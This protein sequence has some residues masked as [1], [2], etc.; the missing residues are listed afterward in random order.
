[1]FEI[2]WLI[3]LKF[4]DQRKLMRTTGNAVGKAR[5][6]IIIRVANRENALFE[7]NQTS[8]HV[9][10]DKLSL[11]II[12]VGAVPETKDHRVNVHIGT[13]IQL[14]EIAL[15]HKNDS[16][17]NRNLVW[18]IGWANR[19]F[20]TCGGGKLRWKAQGVATVDGRNVRRLDLD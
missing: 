4:H 10:C 13:E 16:W 1:M 12:V 14:V 2:R 18:I 19:N 6:R 5:K 17:R 11:K 15:L 8:E 20:Q 7:T 3:A 9:A